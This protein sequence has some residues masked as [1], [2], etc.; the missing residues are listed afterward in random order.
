MPDASQY[1]FKY[2]EVLE[3]LIKK[4]DLHEGRWQLILSLGLA[5]A[6]FGPTPAEV[7]PGAAV[8]VTGIGLQ[9]ATPDSP[10]ALTIDAAKANPASSTERPQPLKQSRGARKK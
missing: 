1:M 6:N 4:A 9:K 8:A 5:G 10:D 3:A 2:Q 7:V